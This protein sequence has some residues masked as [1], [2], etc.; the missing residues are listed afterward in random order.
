MEDVCVAGAGLGAL[1]L[2]KLY[3]IRICSNFVSA[4]VRKCECMGARSI[5][6]PIKCVYCYS[7][8][9]SGAGIGALDGSIFQ[10]RKVYSKDSWSQGAGSERQIPPE[11]AQHPGGDEVGERFACRKGDGFADGGDECICVV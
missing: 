3:S 9:I 6:F 4:V 8:G 11:V 7:V 5:F 10:G 2:G 1:L